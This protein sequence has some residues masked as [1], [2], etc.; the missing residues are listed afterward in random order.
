MGAR[1]IEAVLPLIGLAAFGVLTLALLVSAAREALSDYLDR[2]ALRR[3]L[4]GRWSVE[5][6]Q[7]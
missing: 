3:R 2:R 5:R 6:R 4:A 1:I 7:R